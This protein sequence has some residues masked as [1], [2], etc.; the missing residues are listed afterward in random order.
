MAFNTFR[1]STKERDVLRA[2]SVPPHPT[3]T[4]QA[5]LL[6]ASD[7]S[8]LL[9]NDTDLLQRWQQIA[10]GGRDRNDCMKEI[11]SSFPG[12]VQLKCIKLIIEYALL[13]RE[14]YGDLLVASYD[15]Y[16]TQNLYRHFPEGQQHVNTL[17]NELGEDFL[18]TVEGARLEVS[19][20]AT[21][22]AAIEKRWEMPFSMAIPVEFQ[23]G[24]VGRHFARAFNKLTKY[25]THEQAWGKDSKDGLLQPIIRARIERAGRSAFR[26]SLTLND[27]QTAL[28]QMEPEAS[29][30]T[31]MVLR[32][33]PDRSALMKHSTTTAKRPWSGRSNKT[34]SK[35]SKGLIQSEQNTVTEEEPLNTC[36]VATPASAKSQSGDLA[37]EPLTLAVS[38]ALDA[39]A[40]DGNGL[41]GPRKTGDAE[42]EETSPGTGL[43]VDIHHSENMALTNSQG[44]LAGIEA[45]QQKSSL[46]ADADSN[47]VNATRLTS[48]AL[49][50]QDSGN[51]TNLNTVTPNVPS[52]P[53]SETGRPGAAKPGKLPELIAETV[54]GSNLL[55]HQSKQSPNSQL[56]ARYQADRDKVVN[57]ANSAAPDKRVELSSDDNSDFVSDLGDG[58]GQG[59][60]E[61]DQHPNNH[62]RIAEKKQTLSL[63]SPKNPQ[64]TSYTGQ[65][66]VQKTLVS[67]LLS[68]FK[69][70]LCDFYELFDLEIETFI[71]WC[72]TTPGAYGEAFNDKEGLQ[73]LNFSVMQQLLAQDSTVYAMTLSQHA[74]KHNV[75]WKV[76]SN[77]SYPILI[78]QA[79]S[80]LKSSSS[81]EI[82]PYDGGSVYYTAY[83]HRVK[84]S[85]DEWVFPI[86]YLIQADLDNNPL[87]PAAKMKDLTFSHV[88]RRMPEYQ[89]NIKKALN[90]NGDH[91]I[92]DPQIRFPPCTAV[93]EALLGMRTWDNLLVRGEL[94]KIWGQPGSNL[95]Y[96]RRIM[97]KT[98]E[99]Y[100]ACTYFQ[101]PTGWSEI[102]QDRSSLEAETSMSSAVQVPSNASRAS[103]SKTAIKPLTSP[104]SAVGDAMDTIATGDSLGQVDNLSTVET[105]KEDSETTLGLKAN[106][107]MADKAPVPKSQVPRGWRKG[108]DDPPLAPG[109]SRGWRKPPFWGPASLPEGFEWPDS[110][111]PCWNHSYYDA[112]LKGNEWTVADAD[113]DPSQDHN[114]YTIESL[115]GPYT[116]DDAVWYQVKWEGYPLA[117]DITWEPRSELLE[118]IPTVLLELERALF[119][120]IGASIGL[121]AERHSTS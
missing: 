67:S 23:P 14:Q 100:K 111:I 60:E 110:S 33:L 84:S 19:A 120:R 17:C 50:S 119:D 74:R 10:V 63:R 86:E 121:F 26:Q 112:W 41:Q 104:G 85:G 90:G 1:V 21:A 94:S 93:G 53:D 2:S 4:L 91:P 64:E 73:L 42:L 47:T 49:Q 30:D 11:M 55:P 57:E 113:R 16:E 81:L 54:A 101:V 6:P 97:E 65:S 95:A 48:G 66:L 118:Q 40:N 88:T 36:V 70:W 114:R 9:I 69:D 31:R 92:Y 25:C 75:A 82:R 80:Q 99:G 103:S 76:I 61:E 78:P 62:P 58:D 89:L 38:T 24:T 7:T 77:L 98:Q 108:Y 8:R 59:H 39:A 29:T 32:D 20:R 83:H 15:W 34:S 46:A 106:K 3:G 96:V 44:L 107:M 28:S 68:D 105:D 51:N 115:D 45:D 52:C 116:I 27:L 12:P 71:A 13:Q 5:S 117:K 35:K 37:S 43:D 18:T 87:I 79:S 72:R 102:P 56:E 109:L 22:V